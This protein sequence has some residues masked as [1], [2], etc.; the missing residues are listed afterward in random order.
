MR[1]SDEKWCFR[2]ISEKWKMIFFN[3][4]SVGVSGILLTLVGFV[5]TEK[6]LESFIMILSVMMFVALNCGG[7]YK[8]AA[9]HARQHAHV[10]IAA[11][12]FTKCLALFS[13]PAL[14]AF[15]V[16]TESNRLEW[17]PVF[18]TL[19]I[20]MFVVRLSIRQ[21]Q[22]QIF[23]PTLSLHSCSPMNLRNG[24]IRKRKAMWKYRRMRQSAD[25]KSVCCVY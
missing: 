21:I 14:V 1:E 8:C 6:K 15:F 10:V 7:F 12:Q 19:G 22:K 18:A 20:A 11:I 16:T 23:S 4:L 25:G 24:L 3:T 13:A 17:I 2:V 5:P 9:L